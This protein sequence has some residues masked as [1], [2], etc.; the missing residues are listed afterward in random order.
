[1]RKL[2]LTVIS[3]LFTA[4]IFA[5]TIETYAVSGFK[6]EYMLPSPEAISLIKPV[7]QPE[8]LYTGIPKV[9]IPLW[10]NQYSDISLAISYHAPGIMVNQRASSVGLGWR[11][12]AGGVVARIVRGLPDDHTNGYL[13]LS[14]GTKAFYNKDLDEYL[15]S[16]A[17]T[18]Y[19]YTNIDPAPDLFVYNFDGIKGRFVFDENGNIVSIPSNNL[20]IEADIQPGSN[21]IIGFTIITPG[22]T[23][24]K[25][26]DIER[27]SIDTPGSTYLGYDSYNSA[28][29][30]TTQG[31]LESEAVS[32]GYE[33]STDTVN[34]KLY[35][36]GYY[37]LSGNLVTTNAELTL[38]ISRPSLDLIKD[39]NTEITIGF[40]DDA[41]LIN[42][43]PVNHQY[44]DQ[45]S[46][47][48]LSTL[49]TIT[50]YK[51]N[52][53][54][55]DGSTDQSRS[56]RLDSIKVGVSDLFNTTYRFTYNTTPIPEVS[57]KEQDIW[58]YYNNN[59]ATSMIPQ[60]NVSGG[61]YES[62]GLSSANIPGV[63]RNT[64]E[65]YVKAGILERIENPRG[66][67]THYEFEANKFIYNSQVIHG[68][69]LRVKSINYYDG[70]SA[71]AVRTSDYKYQDSDA[72]LLAKPNFAYELVRNPGTTY[73]H[74]AFRYANYHYGLT[75]YGF[76]VFYS[77]VTMDLNGLGESVYDFEMPVNHLS[78][79]NEYSDQLLIRKKLDYTPST[80]Q[81]YSTDLWYEGQ[82]YN[83]YFGFAWN[84]AYLS[85][86]SHYDL[87]ENLVKKTVYTYNNLESTGAIHGLYL[88]P[89]EE[90][91]IEQ[92]PGPGPQ[93][94]KTWSTRR[95]RKFYYPAAWKLLREKEEFAYVNGSLVNSTKT[96]IDY[97]VPGTQY[98]LPIKTSKTD[99]NGNIHFTEVKYPYHYEYSGDGLES[100]ISDYIDN[101][102]EDL[103]QEP[104]AYR[105]S[106]EEGNYLVLKSVSPSL[107]LPEPPAIQTAETYRNAMET[108][109]SKNQVNV[110]I[111]IIEGIDFGSSKKITRASL[112]LYQKLDNQEV[113]PHK[114]MIIEGPVDYASVTKS[115][116]SS[117]FEYDSDYELV[118]EYSLYS[119]LGE[120]RQTKGADGITTS[121]EYSANGS[122]LT[123]MAVNAPYT[124]IE[125]Y[126]GTDEPDR[127]GDYFVTTYAYYPLVGKT[128]ETDANARSVYYVYDKMGR[129]VATMDH[130]ENIR[131][132][133]ERN[134][135]NQEVHRWFST[136]TDRFG[137]HTHFLR[138]EPEA[139]LPDI[140]VH[141]NCN[142]ISF[143]IIN[144]NPAF[145]YKM[146]YGHP[147]PDSEEIVT[148]A[149][150]EH[151]YPDGGNYM[152]TMHEMKNGHVVNSDEKAVS[153]T[154]YPIQADFTYTEGVGGSGTQLPG[155]TPGASYK[156]LTIDLNLTKGSG[157]YDV[158][159]DIESTK[160]IISDRN[161]VIDCSGTSTFVVGIEDDYSLTCTISDGVQTVIH[162]WTFTIDFSAG[163]GGL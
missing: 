82:D 12:E 59:H 43:K 130:E 81:S 114:E 31:T 145:E 143:N 20:K 109:K 54:L 158:N 133:Y 83:G 21:K 85:M 125:D 121:Y 10:N 135:K 99:V 134:V 103:M 119:D 2:V 37:D 144:Y 50:F 141:N 106:V 148:S 100:T 13:S 77:Q 63:S 34:R 107:I 117:V 78:G 160:G 8:E 53:S 102:K 68:G 73:A 142:S 47:P 154:R 95:V 132:I 62:V 11:L 19:N 139:Y 123:A 3:L 110:P 84:S 46:S 155:I 118:K 55:A 112:T 22:G 40:T 17:G 35:E 104:T 108:L 25:F 18:F 157:K 88:G 113:V 14:P 39:L 147:G 131:E 111:E 128:R 98:R 115:G 72:V 92:E 58:G 28:W 45:S 60:L 1:M 124:H 136:L 94:D 30:L 149:N 23:E 76:P 44:P 6:G 42:I 64:L 36:S 75:D 127:T 32:Y 24:Y 150:V 129:L 96:E 93:L 38:Q 146:N 101:V 91:H 161:D 80:S 86:E 162:T 9:Q 89:K 152:I 105:T 69:G 49:R 7:L 4:N 5:Q 163:G 87:N 29:Y 71:T 27:I 156:A 51:G 138:T 66:G 33:I 79:V 97:D 137:T 41:G 122:Y 67:I 153:I 65:S 61:I 120:L 56:A 16:D 151:T 74:D 159:W 90:Y 70:I 116:L 140:T 126:N 48:F 15:S 26:N 52:Y 57:S